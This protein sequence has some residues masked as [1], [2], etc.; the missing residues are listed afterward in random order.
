M[1]K[2][3]IA[4][5]LVFNFGIGY[6]QNIEIEIKNFKQNKAYLASLSGEKVTPTDTIKSSGEGVFQFKI[7]KVKHISGIYRI[8]FDKNKW[9]DFVND[10]EDINITTN[11]N[12]ILDSLKV[13]SS[14]S[15]KLYYTF[16]KLNK[17]YKSKSDLLQLIL[18]R[19]PNDDDY[20]TSSQNKL[21][22]LQT[23][24][25]DFVNVTS[26]KNPKSFIA[27]YIKSS[28]LPIVDGAIPLEKQVNYLK[29]HSLDFVDFHDADL[30]NSD[31]FSNKSIEYLTY[32]RNPQLPKDLLE[33]EFM[34]AVDTILNKAK[35]NEAVYKHI[36]EYLLD[37]FKKFGFDVIINYI[38]EN[39]VIKDDIC[40]DQKLETA[41]HRR[42]DQ[43]KYFK[44]G[45]KVPDIVMPD[46]S[47][48]QISLYSI[49]A[50]KILILFYASWCQHCN[51]LVPQIQELYK[52]QQKRHIEVLAISID[53]SRS[54]WLNFVKSSGLDWINASDLKGWRGKVANDYFLYATPTMFLIDNERKII[55]KPLTLDD[56]VDDFLQPD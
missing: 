17:Q 9:L 39:Y 14:E 29:A 31:A 36:T 11:A 21:K 18:A 10:G 23:D 4:V 7:N 47:G 55:A 26:Q 42:F 28:Q 5:I 19:Y 44:V 33:K 27:R 40:I 30:I 1:I 37:G 22:Q 56:F 13:L 35:V 34:V 16:I 50:E 32:F 46:S 54:D 24:Y 52:N 53:T 51:T 48:K 3:L 41:L 6:S 45:D 38:L 43:A 20:Y 12:N 2:Y 25:L 8:T 49:R 15:N